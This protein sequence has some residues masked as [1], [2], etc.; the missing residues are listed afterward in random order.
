MPAV[1]AKVSNDLN[2][3]VIHL[4]V[5]EQRSC[6][7][8]IH[9]CSACEVDELDSPPELAEG[10]IGRYRSDRVPLNVARDSEVEGCK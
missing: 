3:T 1:R 2:S 10:G 9:P 4:T 6:F 7:G 8:K 5:T